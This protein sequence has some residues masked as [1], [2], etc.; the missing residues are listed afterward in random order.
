MASY[1]IGTK[2]LHRGRSLR[3]SAILGFD[4][5]ELADENTDERTCAPLSEVTSASTVAFE[6]LASASD[7]QIGVALLRFPDLEPFIWSPCRAADV[8]EL[9]AKLGLHRAQIYALIRS[10]RDIPHPTYLVPGKPGTKQGAR[11]LA[12]QVE[13]IITSQV[14]AAHKSGLSLHAKTIC[15]EIEADCDEAGVKAPCEKTVARRISAI[16]PDL[17]LRKALGKRRAYERTHALAGSI[18][19]TVPL[20]VV[21][22]DHSPL[23]IFLVDSEDRTPISRAFMTLVVDTFSRA[24]LG[25]HLGLDPP[26]ALPVALAL[27]HAVMPKEEWLSER[28]LAGLEWPMFGVM[29]VLRVDRAS[30]FK[31]PKFE[32]ACARWGIDVQ[33]RQKK[34]DGGF[35][36]RLIGT[37]Q[38]WASQEPG[39]SGNDPKKKRGEPDGTL[40]AE[41]TLAEAERWLARQIISRYHV[42]RHSELGMS[43][44]QAWRAWYLAEGS[45][46]LPLAIEDREAFF[47]SFLP[48]CTRVISHDGISLFDESYFCNEIRPYVFPGV[49]RVVHYD[50]RR[51]GKLYV[52]VGLNRPVTVPYAD[53]TKPCIPKFELDH[54]RRSMR[55]RYPDQFDLAAR[56]SLV[57]ENRRD[58]RASKSATNAARRKERLRQSAL[59]EAK[60]ED[61]E[62]PTGRANNVSDVDYSRPPTVYDVGPV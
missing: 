39:A 37:L 43:P 42:A 41:K 29:R 38:A 62:A 19:T 44:N 24:V 45:Q 34:E 49:R 3:I 61:K 5:V 26:G 56:T 7:Q 13:K 22:V 28:G 31:S 51:L 33:L 1:A 50:P 27:T 36:E 16:Y 10:L 8:E 25:F 54:Q 55:A 11:C 23:D 60:R 47:T 35:I 32:A 40:K 14:T 2:V 6:N 21:E 46:R 17:L 48:S 18:E 52:D 30:E 12:P 15:G 57:R 4:Y 59:L 20:A 9:Q 53:P 58:R